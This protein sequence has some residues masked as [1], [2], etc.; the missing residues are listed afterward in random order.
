MPSRRS[1]P[2]KVVVFQCPCGTLA[3][4]RCPRMARPRNRAIFVEAPVSSMN[5][6]RSGSRSGWASN[7]AWR[8][9]A[10]PGRSCSLACAVFFEGEIV[11]VQEAPD[12]AAGKQGPVIAL[13][14]VRQLGQ[15][16]VLLRLDGRQ[17][18]VAKR[19]DPMRAHIAAHWQRR[20]SSLIPPGP[21]PADRRSYTDPEPL[22][23]S[24][25][26]R[27]AIDGS[28]HTGP[29]IWAESCCHPCW[30]PIQPAWRITST[31]VEE[32][33]YESA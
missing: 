10:T 32:S 14:H 15:R 2:T 31:R 3:R 25:S 22:S 18:D 24:V 7:Q 28:D 33:D 4:H 9:A 5:T 12:R 27:A 20:Q 13:E 21:Q 29:K 8:R 1:A 17:D 19:L 11:A 23:G 30:P 6:R 26:G 16:D